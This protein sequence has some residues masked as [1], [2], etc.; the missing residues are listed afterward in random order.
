M[1]YWML[2]TSETEQ[3]ISQD[4]FAF[5]QINKLKMNEDEWMN[6]VNAIRDVLKRNKAKIKNQSKTIPN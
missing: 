6:E 3:G 1:V 2:I 4:W 5:Y